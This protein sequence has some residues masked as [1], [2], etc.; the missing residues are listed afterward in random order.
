MDALFP[1]RRDVTLSGRTQSEGGAQDRER[2]F[3]WRHKKLGT[4][5]ETTSRL[6]FDIYPTL[7]QS[8]WQGTTQ[9]SIEFDEEEF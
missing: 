5:I 6:I 1:N 4:G 3:Y 7:R 2:H 9:K 8:L